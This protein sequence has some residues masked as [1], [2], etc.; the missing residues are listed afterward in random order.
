MN[1]SP[2][3]EKCPNIGPYFPAF[4]LNTERYEVSLP[5]QSEC[6]KI[7]TRSNSVFGQFLCS[8]HSVIN[9]LAISGPREEPIVIPSAF[10]YI[11]LLK[12]KAVS[13]QTSVINFCI[14][15]FFHVVLTNFS[16]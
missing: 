16:S 1:V 10:L 14:V 3:R 8:A 6:G 12:P 13:L 15:R 5:I 7:R 2:L 4:G 11:L 9:I